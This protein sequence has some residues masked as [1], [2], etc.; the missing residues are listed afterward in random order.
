MHAPGSSVE[1]WDRRSW[2]WLLVVLAAGAVVLLWG[3]EGGTMRVYDEGLYGQLGRNALEHGQFMHAVDREGGLYPGFTKP[4]LSIACV[5][6]SFRALGVSMLA[7]RLPFA[8]SML[9]LCAVAF[10]WGRRIGGLAMAVGWAGCLLGV[11]ACM[12]WGRVACVEPMLMLWIVLGLWAYHEALVR[13]GGSGLLWAVGAGVALALAMATKQVVVGLAVV[14]IVGLELH[15]REGRRAL[16]RLALALGP[17][18]VVGVAWLWWM[19]S[20]FGDAAIDLYVRTGVVRRVAGFE[21]G[22]GARSLNE[23]ARTVSEACEPFPWVL[24]VAGLVLLLLMRPADDRRDD[25]APLLAGLLVTAV[26]VYDNL[27]QS[28]VPWYA[29]DVVVPLTAGLGFL[30]AGV[31]ETRG[32]RLGMARTAGGVLALG[33]GAVGM[34]G[35][36][37]SQLDV[38]V[39]VGVAALGVMRRP[40]L[41]GAGRVALMGAAAVAFVVG[42]LHDPTLWLP[43]GGH[44]QLMRTLAAR[45]V[46][47]VDVDADTR[48]GGEYPLVTYYGPAARVVRRPPWRGEGDE[49]PQAYVTS[50][51]WPLELHP[52]DGSEIVRAPGVMAFLGGDPRRAAWTSA[53]LDALL[54]AGPLTFEAEHMPS[55]RDDTLRS[56]PTA[57]GGRVRARVPDGPRESPFVLTHGPDLG[58][59]RGRYVARFWLRWDCGGAVGGQPAAQVRV[60]ASNAIVA[61]REVGCEDGEPS[62]G[63]EPVEVDVVLPRKAV[64]ELR[65]HY[66]SGAVWHDR[67]ELVR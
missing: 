50:A 31:V 14:P 38:A 64:V 22:H 41:A 37:V 56:D 54:D 52:E 4:P 30:V 58:L 35:S 43:P 46:T 40:A 60:I 25:G 10:C 48:L 17:A 29:L 24:G 42:T 13:R 8:L 63:F 20:R 28:L 47:R 65:V 26:V 5:A 27:S 3:L 61:E 44:E 16:P 34:L 1:G 9:G 36:V 15:R 21:S 51:L 18:V 19:T 6:L 23:L 11:A 57:S 7:L 49:A 2:A 66:V 32:D 67:T 45:G 53:T 62:G 33:V 39:L 12:R 59:P 55:Q